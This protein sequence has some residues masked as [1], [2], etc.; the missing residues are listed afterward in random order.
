[1]Q[2][3]VVAVHSGGL[4]RVQ[5][6]AGHEVLA[7][8][9]GRM[10]RFRIKVVPGDRV[11]VGVSPV[12]SGPRASSPSAPASQTQFEF[13]YNRPTPS[14]PTA[15]AVAASRSRRGDRGR[16]ASR[17]TATDTP[18]ALEPIA[19]RHDADPVRRRSSLDP[20]LL[21]GVRDL[22]FT[23]T[24]PVQSAV[25]PLALAGHDVIACAETGTGKTLRVRR[26][27]SS[28]GC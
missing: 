14:T 23:E 19:V 28:S 18:P 17:R 22:G 4:Y 1:M 26:R 15:P 27:R 6:D 11:T 24:R 21:E 13:Q 25:I 5:C 8:L 2:G 12:R 7:Q 20:R 3:T 10:R 16:R 9:S